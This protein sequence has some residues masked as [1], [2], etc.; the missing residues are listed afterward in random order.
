MV[1]ALT[2]AVQSTAEAEAIS[3][4]NMRAV[5]VF[6]SGAEEKYQSKINGMFV[7][8]QEKGLDGR[9]IYFK[10]GDASVLMEHFRGQWQIKA[11]S[12]KGKNYR[13]AFVSGGCAP[14]A[15]T[16]RQKKQWKE[17]D[18]CGTMQHSPVKVATGAEAEQKVSDCSLRAHEHMPRPCLQLTFVLR[19]AQGSEGEMKGK[20]EEEEEDEE[21]DEEEEE[22]DDEKEEEELQALLREL[23]AE[24]KEEE[25]EEAEEEEGDA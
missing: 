22:E 20:E 8:G 4:D 14:E 17:L 24:K 18:V 15:C 12:E 6:I 7:P 25:A 3:Q 11:A 23:R 16:S 10:D 5:P 9:V 2:L 1:C 19:F 13:Y 21:E